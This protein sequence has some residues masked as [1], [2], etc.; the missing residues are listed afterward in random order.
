MSR[1]Y[2]RPPLLVLLCAPAVGLS[3][4]AVAAA[5][6]FAC[7]VQP[8]MSIAPRASGP[9]GSR[10]TVTGQGFVGPVELRW[11]TFTGARVGSAQGPSFAVP[12]VIPRQ[13]SGL[14]ALI[15]LGRGPDGSVVDTGRAEFLITGPGGSSAAGVGGLNA[16]SRVVSRSVSTTSDGGLAIAAGLSGVVFLFV[17]GVAGRSWQRRYSR[18]PRSA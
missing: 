3:C 18:P 7:V 15:A 10:V 13:S 9:A 1:T 17:G 14:Y 8:V 2:R 11:N 12:V 16:R 4:L 5:G 6:A